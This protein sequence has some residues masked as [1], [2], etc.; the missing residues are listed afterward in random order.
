MAQ[1]TETAL[2][3]TSGCRTVLPACCPIQFVV[4]GTFC[5]ERVVDNNGNPAAVLEASL[6]FSVEG[7]ITISAG[8]A[9]TGTAT[10][11]LYADQLGGPFDDQI[12]SVEVQIPGDGTYDWT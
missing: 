4:A 12:G 5:V 9:I 10:V 3:S 8:N 6:P 1:T 7:T 2:V 11:T